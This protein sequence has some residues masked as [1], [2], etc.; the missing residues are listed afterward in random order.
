MC[1]CVCAYTYMV[2]VCVMYNN[3]H[4]D[5]LISADSTCFLDITQYAREARGERETNFEAAK[6]Q[7]QAELAEEEEENGYTLTC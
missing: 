2:H 5:C 1:V 6:A 7:K 4:S 3:C